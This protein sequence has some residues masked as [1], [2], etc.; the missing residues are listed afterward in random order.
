[1]ATLNSKVKPAKVK[2]AAKRALVLGAWLA[3]AGSTLAGGADATSFAARAEAEYHRAQNQ[4][5][6]NTNDATAAWEFA[7]ACFDFDDFVTNNTDH[8]TIANRG[9]VACRQAIAHKPDSAPAHYYLGQDLG[10]LARTETLGA[11]KI[12]K[13]MEREYKTAV[14]LDG[15]FDY[16]G[17]ERSLGLLYRD[18]P[19]WPLSLG[20]R[21]KARDW[22]ELADKLAPEY[23]ENHLNLVESYLQWH[24]RT[25]AE[26]ELKALNALW[27]AARTNL[28][29]PAWERSWADW[30][31]RREVARK[32]LGE[33]PKA[34][35]PSTP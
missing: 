7:R 25:G 28:V 34:A 3:V 11:L 19:G 20:S 22:L 35:E 12:V 2:P 15:H 14:R 17:P 8:A 24:D 30:S 10:Q 5:Q 6:S 29:G 31:A 33:N 27:P 16:A 21:H 23:P 9:I 18:A 26:R 1:M 4:F 32:N 13:E